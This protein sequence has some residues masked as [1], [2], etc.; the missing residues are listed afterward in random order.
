L[1]EAVAVAGATGGATSVVDKL[2]D[3]LSKMVDKVIEIYS[4]PLKGTLISIGLVKLTGLISINPDQIGRDLD[5]IADQLDNF[6]PSSLLGPA[7]SF[8]VTQIFETAKK[9]LGL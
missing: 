1:A 4:D 8:D 3:F 5:K 2:S 7:P 6:D 9:T